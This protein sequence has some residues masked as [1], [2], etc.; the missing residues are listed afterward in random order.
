MH[1]ISKPVCAA[2]LAGVDP[3]AA[4]MHTNR[5]CVKKQMGM[6]AILLSVFDI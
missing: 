1:G 3:A 4:L 6:A 2:N 5:I